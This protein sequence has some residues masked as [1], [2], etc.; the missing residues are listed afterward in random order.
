LTAAARSAI[1]AP[2]RAK[3]SGVD[4]EGVTAIEAYEEHEI[5]AWRDLARAAGEQMLT[6]DVSAGGDGNILLMA[7]H[8]CAVSAFNRVLGIGCRGPAIAEAIAHAMAW[9]EE[10]GMGSFWLQ[11]GAGAVLRNVEKWL[12]RRRFVHSY[13][14]VLLALSSRG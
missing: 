3:G 5:R 7:S 14:S 13:E 8:R 11:L 1:V 2:R 4:E 9:Y 10:S 6:S 12:R